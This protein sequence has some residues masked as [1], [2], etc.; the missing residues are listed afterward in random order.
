MLPVDRV[1]T[2]DLKDLHEAIHLVKA[3][4]RVIK[5][6]IRDHQI[7]LGGPVPLPLASAETSLTQVL[8]ALRRIRKRHPEAVSAMDAPPVRRYRKRIPPPDPSPRS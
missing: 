2:A 4:L 8:E 5:A 7:A 6:R 1:T 3:E